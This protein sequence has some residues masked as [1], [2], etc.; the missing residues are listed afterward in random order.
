MESTKFLIISY[1]LI[2]LNIYEL[3]TAVVYSDR[4]VTARRR[5]TTTTTTEEFNV[6]EKP[7]IEEF[8]EK[9]LV[10][11]T[12]E[13]EFI[14]I[15]I[16]FLDLSANSGSFLDKLK[17]KITSTYEHAK[18]KFCETP[19]NDQIDSSNFLDLFKSSVSK[20]VCSGAND[21]SN[22]TSDPPSK[23]DKKYFFCMIFYGI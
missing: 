20:R 6:E 5:P 12:E 21:R 2:T 3:N 11:K 10:N 4:K 23:S 18:G 15:K 16:P 22:S 7:V 9:F 19:K 13:N 8:N 1:F 17:S 14:Q